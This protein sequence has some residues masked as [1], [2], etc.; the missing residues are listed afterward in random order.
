MPNRKAF[1]IWVEEVKLSEFMA[2]E[3]DAEVI[4]SCKKYWGGFVIPVFLRY[5]I[6]SLD[7]YR[8]LQ[9]I[10][11]QIIFVQNPPIVA[12]LVVYFYAKL[13]SADYVIDTHTAGF[14]DRKWIFFHWLHKFLAKRALWSTAHN[15]KNLE[16]FKKWGVENSSVLQ[17]YNPTQ[18]EIL[19]KNITLPP[20]LENIL[21]AKKELAVFMV[22]RFAEDD[23]WQGVAGTAKLMPDNIFFLTGNDKKISAEIKN[24]FP[25]NVILT[26]YL[27]HEQFIYLM[28]RC[29]V[30]LALTKRR[31]TVLWSIREIMALRKPFITSDSEAIRHYFSNVALFTNHQPEDL[32]TKI[33]E[34]WNRRAEIEKNIIAFLEKDAIRWKNDILF[35]NQII[36]QKPRNDE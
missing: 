3:I 14:I 2:R 1:V 18:A 25:E 21:T 11:P 7:T 28:N 16:F 19:N 32:K 36:N 33:Q 5:L 26:G 24:R 9:K 15:Y 10:K 4:I 35:I 20:E 6:Q 27:K 30:V 13:N 34:A 22:N 29:D 8:K 31:D 12:V 17:F 23:A